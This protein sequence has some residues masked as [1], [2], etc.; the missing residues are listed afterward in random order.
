VFDGVP[1]IRTDRLLLRPWRDSDLEPFAALNADPVVMEFMS[2]GTLSRAD[3]DAWVVRI[4]DAW[5][6]NGYGLWAV[7]VLR[8]PAFVGFVGLADARF[9]AHFTPAIEVGWRLARASW[10]Y[11]FATEGARAAL[12][13]GFQEAKLPEILTFTA[14]ANLR[15]RAVMERLGMKRDPAGDFD[16]P[17][18]PDGHPVQAHVLYR[19]T[20]DA[21]RD[22][23]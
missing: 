13:F 14:T 15:S 18:V 19:L 6:T 10:G 20:D 1:E 16:H 9:E 7:E 17:A 8:G 5:E 12:R 2:R 21:R 11:G 3:S 22:Y 23:D 4:N